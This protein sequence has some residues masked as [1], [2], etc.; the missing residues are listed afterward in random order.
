[1]RNER[2]VLLAHD[3]AT[4]CGKEAEYKLIK[5]PQRKEEYIICIFYGKERA[6]RRIFGKIS[7]VAMIYDL[8]VRNTVTPCTLCD[9]IE[10]ITY[11]KG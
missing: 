5:L 10:D 9:V 7:D 6:M 8:I 11:Q 3:R 1:M 2:R 4:I